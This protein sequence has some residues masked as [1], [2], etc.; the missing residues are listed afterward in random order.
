[1]FF[2]RITLNSHY[3]CGG[4]IGEDDKRV[5]WV[6]KPNFQMYIF[7]HVSQHLIPHTRLLQ[8]PSEHPF[9]DVV[10]SR[11][12]L[13][14]SIPH[15]HPLHTLH[16]AADSPFSNIHFFHSIATSSSSTPFH[17]LPRR[18]HQ[19]SPSDTT[20]FNPLAAHFRSSDSKI[21]LNKTVRCEWRK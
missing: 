4:E 8:F 7:L 3:V 16:P 5:K 1:M 13:D 14:I 17:S 20:R 9:V 12:Q 21:Y 10:Y 19:D 2:F 15:Q 6:E 18:C 11:H